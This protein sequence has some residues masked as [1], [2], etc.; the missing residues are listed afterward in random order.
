[1]HSLA[2]ID[3]VVR[4]CRQMLR[5]TG[6]ERAPEELAEKLDVPL[7]TVRYALKNAKDPILLENPYA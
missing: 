2:A 5:E 4:T 1:M 3:E 6:R 7:E